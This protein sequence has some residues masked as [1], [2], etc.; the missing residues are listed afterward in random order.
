MCDEHGNKYIYIR[1]IYT[2]LLLL[3]TLKEGR[4]RAINRRKDWKKNFLNVSAACMV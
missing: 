2:R 1:R 4:N 3:V